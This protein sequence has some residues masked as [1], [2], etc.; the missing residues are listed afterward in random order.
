MGAVLGC[1]AGASALPLLGF[2]MSGIIKGSLAASWQGPA[3][4]SGSLFATLQSLGATGLGNLL[5]GA[6]GLVAVAVHRM[7]V[8]FWF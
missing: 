5:F 8:F 6:V 4:V 7:W 3:V 1:I 2:G